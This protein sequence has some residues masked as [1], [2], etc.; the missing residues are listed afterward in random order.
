[1]KVSV[2]MLAYNHERF[3]AQA[4]D[5]IL[6]QEVDFEYEIVIGEDCST[7]STRQIVIDYQ[8]K[9]PDK[10]RLLLPEKNLGMH[11]NA[12]NTYRACQGQ[13]IAVLEGDDYWT[14][15]DKLQT[16]VRLLD[17]NPDLVICFTNSLMFWED[18]SHDPAIF[19]NEQT[20]IFTIEDLL[21]RNF[22]STP[23]VMYQ[24]GLIKEFP[25]W[26]SE[27]GMGDWT[28]Y[29][30]LA[31]YGKIGYVDEVM[32]AYRIH[33][34]GVWSSK[35]RDYQLS[36]TIRMLNSLQKYFADKN[37]YRYYSILTSSI[38]CYSQQ[39]SNLL[40]SV[41]PVNNIQLPSCIDN[42]TSH[43]LHIGC[44]Q[45]IFEGWINIDIEANHPQV[46]LLCD[47]RT[48]LPF[49]DDSCSLIYN[50]HVLEHL[51]VE[52]GLFFLKEC[53][54][55]LQPGG[56]LRIAMPDLERCV[57]KYKSENWRD[58]DWLTW[59]E[60]QFIQTRAEMMNI[61]FRWWDHKWL[62]DL[63]ELNRRLLEA[64]FTVVKAA[65]WGKSTVP[66]FE[67]RETR[68]DSLLI[69][70]A[71][72]PM[73]PLKSTPLVSVC[74][75][76]YNGEKFIAEAVQSILAQTYPNL[77]I[78]LSD[79]NSTDRT[80]E[81]ARSSLQ[82]SS[83]H[84]FSILEHSQYGLA[85]N[86][87]FCISQ[88]QGKYIKFLFQ[89]DLLVPNAIEKMV[90]LAEQDPEIGLVFSP[91][92]LFTET[93]NT[94]D[95]ILLAN[96]EAENVHKAWSKLN[97][98]QSGQDLLKDL[99]LLN[100]PINKVGEPSTV[101]IKK[102]IF[103]TVG[104][105]NPELCQLVDLEMWLRIMS[106]CKVGYVDRVLSKF[107][108]HSQQQ[109]Q[110][111]S[112]SR[113]TI[114]SDYQ[115]F[116]LTIST[117][118]RYPQFTRQEALY[119]Y[120]ALKPQGSDLQKLCGQIAKQLLVLPDSQLTNWYQGLTG[121]TY[122]ILLNSGIDY[123][124]LTEEDRHFVTHLTQG[125]EQQQ[126]IQALLAA[127]L[128]YRADE[129]PLPHDLDWIPNWLQSDYL[130][131]LFSAPTNFH[132]LTEADRYCHYIQQ[133]IDYLHESILT[134]SGEPFWKN[135][136]NK[137]AQVANFIPIY[138]NEDNLKSIYEKRAAIISLSLKNNGH[139]VDY[140]FD[141]RPANRKKIRLGILA[142]HF[143]PSAETFAALPA[144]EYLSR[145][146]EVVLYSLQQTN[147][148][149]EQY[150]QSSANFFVTLPECL[151]EQVNT[152]RSDDLDIL[153]F[154]TNITA[155]TNQ[156]C[157]LAS[158][159]LARIQITSG[160]SVVTTGMKNMDYF[161]SGTFS[162]PSQ[163]AQAQYQEE[164]I[165]LPGAAHCFS[166]GDFEEKSSLKIDRQDLGIVDDAVVF[167]S[168]AN[169]YKIIPELIHTWAKIIAAVPNSVLMLFPFGPNWS[170]NYPKATFEQHLHQ[171][172][173]EYGVS[174]D[175]VIA[176]DPQ[177]VPN[178]EDLKEYYKL[179]DV[180]LDSYPFAGTTSLIEPLQVSLPVIARQGNS[181]R[182]SMGAAMIRS[183]EITELVADSEESYIQLAVAL[184]NNSELRQQKSAEVKAKM[185]DNPSFL[186]SKGY[187]AK[188][189]E[190]FKEL[191]DRYSRNALSDNLRLKDVNLMVF[192]DWSQSEES[193]GLEL[194]QVIQTLATQPDAQK[195]TLLIDT[196]NIAIEDA[197]M[198]LSSVAMNL[199]MEEDLDIMEELEISLIEDLN[200]IQ[201]D[202]L[203]PRISAR[204]VLD[205]DNQAVVGK[206]SLE[207]LP[208]RQ[209]ESFIVV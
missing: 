50:E 203:L 37:N 167:T 26:Y 102:E 130:Q 61:S 137:F 143:T 186:D 9:H 44:G 84:K 36:E 134:H 22:I 45:N 99:N 201:W 3:I 88:A 199:M 48:K 180:Y 204:I 133:W 158:H 112:L 118:S 139:E 109:T 135:I 123:T 124:K 195:T 15:P 70:E 101:L 150:C 206:L 6:M 106:Q 171:I 113:E 1:M 162:D 126:S 115:R 86:W 73:L 19:S 63:E 74:I 181:F 192:P 87:N 194:Q 111:N 16:Q 40:P 39:L 33:D 207:K 43:K 7:D 14:S 176:L 105:F 104:F 160:G 156:M 28:F 97:P 23:S 120:A 168:G 146:F 205:C 136:A 148:P 127:M 69:V 62:Y 49:G 11:T 164:L 174:P 21:V 110:K 68:V 108:I 177:P 12:M 198:F 96:H 81:I 183:L 178:R 131:F 189:G 41:Q 107:R 20:K 17:R 52:E 197:E 173:A 72:I 29:I 152:I 116:F 46:D 185:A 140:Q 121:Q 188:I 155:V 91:R 196:T 60:Y 157:L 47:V 5:S 98:I 59:P 89:D 93:G 82:Q 190:L 30:L 142:A 193:V 2:F 144:Y 77:E 34:G 184:G 145:E 66:E 79:D 147:H 125:L 64:G 153:F 94:N 138:F 24:N 132:S 208:Q 32:S 169:F 175:R 65:Q 13:Y 57:E 54:R 170:S 90:Y 51:T 187:G 58:Q 38:D 8:K 75:P 92:V 103:D 53:R 179:A 4:I 55:V 35:N 76:T 117:D 129:L 209:L 10:I 100:N 182:S 80:I 25:Q 149:L 85:Q 56:I 166:Y 128:Y 31:E 67:N 95:S 141:E 83:S 165:Q 191:V 159:R 172:F 27:Q 18:N 161:I 78:I 114:L 154:A 163:T 42:N 200:N 119:R 151:A 202:N 122:K 71:E